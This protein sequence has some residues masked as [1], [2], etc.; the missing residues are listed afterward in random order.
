[1]SILLR[2][3]LK[4]SHLIQS[5]LNCIILL[6]R[7]IGRLSSCCTSR[8]TLSISEFEIKINTLS[9]LVNIYC[10]FGTLINVGSCCHKSVITWPWAKCTTGSGPK[11]T[12]LSIAYSSSGTAKFC[13]NWLWLHITCWLSSSLQFVNVDCLCPTLA[14]SVCWG[15]LSNIWVPFTHELR[16]WVDIRLF[17]V[18]QNRRIVLEDLLILAIFGVHLFLALP[19]TILDNLHVQLIISSDNAQWLWLMVIQGNHVNI[20][21]VFIG[22]LRREQASPRLG[23]IP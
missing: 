21:K 8:N 15:S 2:L 20:L 7:H 19:S 6:S 13:S 9:K 3:I 5:V 4:R 18:I 10:I 22:L 11:I 23:F 14:S 1:M 12:K 17:F 16:G